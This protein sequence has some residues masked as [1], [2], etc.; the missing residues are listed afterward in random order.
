MTGRVIYVGTAKAYDIFYD[1]VALRVNR[2]QEVELPIWKCRDLIENTNDCF[3]LTCETALKLRDML[4]ERL[5][6]FKDR[7]KGKRVFLLG[8]GAS[9][10]GFDFSRLDGEQ[11]IVINHTLRFYDKAKYLLFLDKK[12]VNECNKEIR[13][14]KGEIITSYRTE[15]NSHNVYRFHVNRIK[16]EL[17]LETGL[18]NGKS[19]GLAA[20]NAALIMGAEKIYLL[21]FDLIPEPPYYFFPKQEKYTYG[22]VKNTLVMFEQYKTWKDKIFNCSLKSSIELFQKVD[23]EDVLK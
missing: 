4:P 13:T 11:T 12:F 8:S 17:E 15:Y 21:G 5:K 14:F 22:K 1:G 23:I 19:S 9:L 3:M 2:N 20:I 10:A 7:L 18:Y 16:P 6:G